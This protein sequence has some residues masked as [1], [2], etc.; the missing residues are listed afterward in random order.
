MI[1]VDDF[2]RDVVADLLFTHL[3][4]LDDGIVLVF[5]RLF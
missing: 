3:Q 4:L 5:P 1:A 2:D